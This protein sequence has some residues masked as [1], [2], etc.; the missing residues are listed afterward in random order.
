MNRLELAVL[1][2]GLLAALATSGC[3]ERTGPASAAQT[4]AGTGNA[5]NSPVKSFRLTPNGGIGFD[6]LWFS[7]ELHAVLAPAGGTGCVDLFD[8]SSLAQTALCGIGPGGD[9]TGGHGEG[10]TSADVGAGLIFAIDRSGRHLHVVD[11]KS[12]S[13]VASAVLAG[14]PD[15]VRWVT[16]QREVWITEPEQEQI[17]VFCLV[18][19]SPPTLVQAGTIAIKGGPESLVI[20]TAHDRAFTHLWQ[21][22][23]VKIA[24]GT[25]MVNP[26]F[27]N[28]CKAS[29]GIALDAERG[30][31]FA[32]CSE[33]KAVALDVEH[34]GAVLATH[35]TPDGVDIISFNPALHRLYVPAASDGSVTVLGVGR[36]GNLSQLGLFQ[37]VKGAHCVASDDQRHVWVC[38][39][40]SG[41]LLMYNDAFPPTEE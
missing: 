22:R 7:S 8:S 40:D 36:R 5:P 28:G 26:S 12:K 10:T 18:S 35:D 14:G 38:A 37:S 25:R 24:L 23:T 3:R 27:A 4:A 17:E 29:R 15:Y 39:P 41:S 20:D 21:G 2:V 6:D 32:G 16:S 31:L 34:D 33:G 13:V 11:P 19:A 9:Y 1:G 30:Q